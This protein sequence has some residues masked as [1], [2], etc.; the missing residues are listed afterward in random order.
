[1]KKVRSK[2]KYQVIDGVRI[3]PDGRQVCTE[4]AAGKRAYLRRI[5]EMLRRQHHI[6]ALCGA[7]IGPFDRASFEHQD[8]RGMGGSNRDDRIEIDGKPYNAVAHGWCNAN[9]GSRRY[10][11][12]DGIYGPVPRKEAA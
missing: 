6:C 7:Y 3:Y 1:M 12:T 4:T 9:K 8:G 2:G 10:C 11:W 5:A